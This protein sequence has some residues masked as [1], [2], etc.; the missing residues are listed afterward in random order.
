MA[1]LEVIKKE[2]RFDFEETGR[3]IEEKSKELGFGV[4]AIHKVSEILKDKGTPI[5]YRCYIYEIC[6][7]GS[8]Q[9]VLKE[10]P[11]VSTAL[12]C[13]I[14]LIERDSKVVVETLKPTDML[15][16]FGQDSL[17]EVAQRVEEKINQIVDYSCGE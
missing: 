14:S 10:S 15:N 4:L 6:H 8:A 16:L 11:E 9:K 7:P 17:K 12:P 2:S 1:K 13:R 3:R 5:D